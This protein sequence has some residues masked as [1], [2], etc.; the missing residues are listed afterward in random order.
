MEV[1]I[2]HTISMVFNIIVTVVAVIVIMFVFQGPV[3]SHHI[4]Y[5]HNLYYTMQFY[6]LSIIIDRLQ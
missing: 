6:I 5:M 2:T 1:S 4:M 3:G